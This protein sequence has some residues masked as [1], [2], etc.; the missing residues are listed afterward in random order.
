MGRLPPRHCFVGGFRH[1][2]SGDIRVG[3]GIASRL[4]AVLGGA[5]ERRTLHVLAG[6]PAGG[7]RFLGPTDLGT[8]ALALG[9]AKMF[10]IITDTL[11]HD[12]IVQRPDILVTAPFLFSPMNR[13][14]GESPI[15]LFRSLWAG[16][17]HS[18]RR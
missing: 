5:R 10:A 17:R 12:A 14:L 16:P 15:D 4:I 1:G 2:I 18:T 9:I 6:G 3:D 8:T 13:M 11:P 7:A